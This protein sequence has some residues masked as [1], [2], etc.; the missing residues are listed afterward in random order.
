MQ[1]KHEKGLQ[2][3]LCSSGWQT[4]AEHVDDCLTFGLWLEGTSLMAQYIN[5]SLTTGIPDS[6]AKHVCNEADFQSHRFANGHHQH[7]T[8]PPPL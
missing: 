7:T 3:Y 5:N 8:S 4:I 6:L 2:K 1:D